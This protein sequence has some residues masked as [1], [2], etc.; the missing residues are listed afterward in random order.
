MI[1][2]PFT[3]YFVLFGAGIANLLLGATVVHEIYKPNVKIPD[4]VDKKE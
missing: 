1:L 2:R 3:R 4:I